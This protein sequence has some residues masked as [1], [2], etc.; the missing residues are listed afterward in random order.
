M[1]I[2]T[3]TSFGWRD[4]DILDEEYSEGKIKAS[5][6]STAFCLDNTVKAKELN[7]SVTFMFG[8]GDSGDSK[9]EEDCSSDEAEKNDVV[10]VGKALLLRESGSPMFASPMFKL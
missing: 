8:F 7:E 3:T 9:T 5:C 4:V 2:R 10:I 1:T 6:E